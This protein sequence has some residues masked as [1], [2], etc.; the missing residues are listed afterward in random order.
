MRSVSKKKQRFNCAAPQM[1]CSCTLARTHGCHS[2][3][4]DGCSHPLAAVTVVNY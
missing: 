4:D 2:V 3:V 1:C